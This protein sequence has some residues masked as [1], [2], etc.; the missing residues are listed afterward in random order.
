M[1]IYLFFKKYY[2]ALWKNIAIY[3]WKKWMTPNLASILSLFIIFPLFILVFYFSSN[4]LVFWILIFLSIN[5]KLVLNAIDWIIAR[6]KNINTKIWMYL[7]VWTDIWPDILII[8]LVLSKIWAWI[9]ILNYISLL[10]FSY[11]L[12]EFIFIHFFNKQN[13]FFWKDL[14]T[15]F[16]IIIFLFYILDLNLIYLVYIYFIF[17]L[18]HNVWFFINKYRN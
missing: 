16:Y 1:E 4:L 2:I 10:T 15:L 11:L 3:L 8:Y 13:L 6:E 5:I 14:R 18:F 9:E 17:F 7:N 12:F